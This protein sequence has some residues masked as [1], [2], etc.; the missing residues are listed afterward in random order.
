MISRE[1]IDKIPLFQGIPSE[2]AA[3]IADHFSLR[4]FLPGEHVFLRGEP[5][6]SMF[7]ILKG[8]VAVTLTNAEGSDYA[9]AT[10]REGGFLG[11]LGLLAGE[12]RS[13]HVKAI[14]ALL[15]AE[16]DQEAYRALTRA[17]PEFNSRLMQLLAKRAA[18]AKVQWQGDRVKSAKG[19]SHSLLSNPE[20]KSENHYPGV[21]KWAKDMNRLVE[22]IASTDTNVLIVGEPGTERVFVARLI[23]S[24][25]KWNSLP[26]ILLNCSEPPQVEREASGVGGGSP[27]VIEDAQESA[28]FGHE[29]GSTAYAKGWRRGYLDIAD[30]GTLLMDHVEH[31]TPKVQ[32]L[33]LRYLQSSC[34]SRIGSNEQRKSK[35][36]IIATTIENMDAMVAQGRFNG[37]LLELLRGRVITITPL[38][39]RKEDIP[40]MA[41]YFLARY[42]RKSH[43]KISGYSKGAIKALV[44][45]GWPSNVA[46]LNTVLNQAVAACQ[47][48]T[49]EEEHIFLDIRPLFLPSAGINLLR[50]EKIS[51]LLRHRLVPGVLQYV[52]VPFFFF[53][54]F[55]TLFGP[56]EQN[57]GNVVAW[58]LL[59][60]LL[61]LS[62]VLGG[63]GF[64]A[65]CPISAISNAFVYGRKTFLP[66][67]GVMKKC[68]IWV[69]AAAFVSIFWIEHVTD[70][71]FDARITGRVFLSILGGAII[72]ALLLGK[73]MWCL[74]ICPLGRM[75][76]NFA[77]LSITELRGNSQVCVS[78]CETRICLKEKN[79]PMG[80]HLSTERTRHDCILCFAC[81]RK[82]KQKSIHLDA[83][84]PHQRILTMKSWNLPRTTFVMLLAGSVL[85]SQMLRWLG[86]HR[87]FTALAIPETHFHTRW[88]NFLALFA[89]TVGFIALT[90]MVSG[91]K[92]LTA[93]RQNF[94]YAGY[95][96]LPL[97]FFGF[98]DIY[99]RQ[100]IL[101]GNEIPR[102]LMDLLGFGN[103][104]NLPK[105]ASNLAILQG[106]PSVLA[107][108][109]G[110]L[111]LYLLRKVRGQYPLR[112]LAY[113]LHQMIISVTCL[114]F[115]IIL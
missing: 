31:L 45:Y 53:L 13:A 85:A 94:V 71:F 73:R 36:R 21:T 63:R 77:V 88:E 68:A 114:A 72:T 96:Y 82:C 34:F 5:G 76:G 102:L 84:L 61:L 80:L 24:K 3:H 44:G 113:R 32:T 33:L 66:F 22:E 35:V 90:F 2:T 69:G 26:F 100:F 39:E 30:M 23:V 42:R 60:P 11:E 62:V 4:I 74:H 108:A 79:C 14:T 19:I 28:L 9:I 57:L 17:F 40:A 97:A 89:I 59:W 101:R 10:L 55:Y 95:A 27:S 54:I 16:I 107:L 37:E 43:E 110:V 70:A 64:C 58:S 111:S 20:P 105:A 15:A 104:I 18:K 99:F 92:R 75:L 12:P 41:E 7:V 50:I 48:K 86:D 112:V 46:E 91:A 56:R 65:Y 93:W 52:T 25:G 109:G 78:Q 51:R 29:P 106:L 1:E 81:V 6:N 98:F 83:L 87:A 8:K 47:G 38:R 67:P 49:I 115:L 103:S